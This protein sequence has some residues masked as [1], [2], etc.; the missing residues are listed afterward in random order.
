MKALAP[1]HCSRL[2]VILFATWAV[3]WGASLTAAAA[4][5]PA[6]SIEVLLEWQGEP[7]LCSPVDPESDETG[8][9]AANNPIEPACAP[10]RG[11]GC[12]ILRPLGWNVSG[13]GCQEQPDTP[14]FVGDRQTYEAVA[15]PRSPIFGYGSATVLCNGGCFK[16]IRKSCH[17]GGEQP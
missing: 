7:Y 11:V 8:A 13:L 3:A 14:I 5:D 16:T 12:T 1:Q 9:A 2:L 6:P 4:Q 10:V 15:V 17:R